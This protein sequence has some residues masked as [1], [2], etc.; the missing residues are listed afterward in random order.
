MN[1]YKEEKNINE[2][3]SDVISIVENAKNTSISNIKMKMY[4][5][6]TDFK[7]DNKLN[8]SYAYKISEDAI[9]YNEKHYLFNNYPS[10][11][12]I[13]HEITHRMDYNEIESWTKKEFRKDVNQISKE[14]INNKQ[15]YEKLFEANGKYEKDIAFSDIIST[16]S[17]GGIDVPFGH[18]KEYWSKNDRNKYT[19]IFANLNVIDYLNYDSKEEKIIVKL[20]KSIKNILKI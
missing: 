14:V 17:D 2:D 13:L 15:Y 3:L 16:L 7:K 1:L 5:E 6:Y 12:A 11:F 20:L 18:S 4:L 19:E 9:H 8:S 10:N